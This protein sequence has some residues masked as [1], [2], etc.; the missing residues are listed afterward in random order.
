MQ[1]NSVKLIW[2]TP[3]AEKMIAFITRVSN[4]KNQ[5]NPKYKGLIKYCLREGH[6]SP[7][8]MANM[9]LEIETTRGI[10]AQIIR[11]RSFSF[12][13]FSQRYSDIQEIM[14][15]EIRR[16]DT[17]NRQNSIDNLPSET[18][19]WFNHESEQLNNQIQ[20]FYKD[21]LDKDIAKECA[22]FIMP[23]SSKTKLY[24]NGTIR[25][26]IHYIQLRTD[27]G[28]Q[29]EHMDIANQAKDI[30]CKELPTIADALGWIE[31]K[32]IPK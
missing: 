22:R 18:I 27:N 32:N 1:N 7:F 19:N 11:H 10:S 5:D 17:K 4:F 12:Q 16:Q 3:D 14:P 6:W 25:S 23:M 31:N 28:T 15:I 8:E 29:K 30:F 9:T 26:W 21:C 2:I 20:Q 13:E 24:M